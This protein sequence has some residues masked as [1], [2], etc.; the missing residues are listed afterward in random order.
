[1]CTESSTAIGMMKIGII[2]LMMWMVFP[3]ATSSA[4]VDSDVTMATII[5]EITSTRLPKNHHIST[6]ITSIASG[7]EIAIW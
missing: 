5:G 7:A 3:V 1:M 6:K 2:E 4:M